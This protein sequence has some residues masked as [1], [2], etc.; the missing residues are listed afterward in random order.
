MECHNQVV[1]IVSRHICADYRLE[2]PKMVDNDRTKIPWDFQIQ[3]DKLVM[4]NQPD[5]VV[6]NKL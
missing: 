1:E 3:T 5:I 4:A 2:F 6:V